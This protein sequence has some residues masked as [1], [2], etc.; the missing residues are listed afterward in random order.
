MQNIQS[1]N[2]FFYSLW[3][4]TFPVF[5][6]TSTLWG[7]KQ[8]MKYLT[9]QTLEA[10]GYSGMFKNISVTFFF[11]CVCAT[12]SLY[13]T[14]VYWDWSYYYVFLF[15]LL[16]GLC[17]LLAILI[18]GTMLSSITNHSNNFIHHYRF[19]HFRKETKY[20]RASFRALQ[21]IMARVSIL[22]DLRPN[23]AISTVHYIF[24]YVTTLLVGF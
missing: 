17:F 1:S 6:K 24:T 22:I 13:C 16:F 8:R 21:P 23:F 5:R 3:R 7:K 11:S 2:G 9:I 15:S 4:K 14:I 20:M 19:C 18:V 10:T 12:L